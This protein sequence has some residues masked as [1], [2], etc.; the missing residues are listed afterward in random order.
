MRADARATDD[1]SRNSVTSHG[2]QTLSVFTNEA[3]CLATRGEIGRHVSLPRHFI[4]S[5]EL[6]C[7]HDVPK[8]TPGR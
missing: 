3:G 4:D 8:V 7:R 5:S 1:E 2:Q 6:P